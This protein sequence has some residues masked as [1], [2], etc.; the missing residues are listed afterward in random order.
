MQLESMKQP[1]VDL[2]VVARPANTLLALIRLFLQT[3]IGVESTKLM[4]VH[5]PK[6][7]VFAKIVIG[8]RTPCISSTK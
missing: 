3:R 6:Q 5:F 4:P 8:K 2:P 1:I 7:Q